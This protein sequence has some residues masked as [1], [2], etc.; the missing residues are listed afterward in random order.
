[1]TQTFKIEFS[2]KVPIV[3][4]EGAKLMVD[5]GCPISS[6]NF[7]AIP[8]MKV[9][10]AHVGEFLGVPGLQMMGLDCLADYILIHYHPIDVTA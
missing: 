7:E 2:K 3:E 1:M 10:L 9:A 5:T 8:G 4:V 6:P